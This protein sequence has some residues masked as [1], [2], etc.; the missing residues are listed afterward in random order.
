M[1]YRI[2]VVLTFLPAFIYGG[3]ILWKEYK[4]NGLR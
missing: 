2:V 4:N 3:Y 1:D